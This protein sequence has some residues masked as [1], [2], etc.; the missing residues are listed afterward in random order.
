MEGVGDDAGVGEGEG[1]DEALGDGG[2]HGLGH[3]AG[4]GA[5]EEEEQGEEGA[6][7]ATAGSQL[8][9]GGLRTTF[10]N[11]ASMLSY[12]GRFDILLR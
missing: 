7:H 10:L 2:G 3:G 1:G 6:H 11:A 8:R 9:G 4:Q 5:G 12:F